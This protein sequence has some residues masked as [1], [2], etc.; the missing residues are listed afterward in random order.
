MQSTREEKPAATKRVES[1]YRSLPA[2]ADTLATPAQTTTSW[3]AP[4]FEVLLESVSELLC[5]VLAGTLI[6]EGVERDVK[7]VVKGWAEDLGGVGVEIDPTTF[8]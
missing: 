3:S 2:L 1:L 8:P 4:R 7:A 5:A 6:G